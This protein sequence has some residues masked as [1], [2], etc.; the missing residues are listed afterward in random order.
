MIRRD[1]GFTLL[2]A[3]AAVAALAAILAGLGAVSGQWMPQWRH[4]FQLV[5][6]DDLIA[7]ALD[8]IVADLSRAQFV[9][10]ESGSGPP[11]FRGDASAVMFV[12]EASG[13]EAAPRLEYVRIGAVATRQGL[14]T[15]RSRAPFAPGPIAPLRDAATLLR[16]PFRLSFAYETLAGEW[17]SSWSAQKTLPR[18][19]RLTVDNGGSQVAVTAFLLNTPTGPDLT[20]SRKPTASLR[21]ANELKWK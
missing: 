6:N 15:Q 1:G 12:R 13:P 16:P 8:R 9:R 4:G 21:P 17:S 3:L 7:Q 18:A 19:V 20:E 10:L 5:Q 14:E 11:Q 2:E